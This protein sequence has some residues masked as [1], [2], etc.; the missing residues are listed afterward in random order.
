MDR[1]RQDVR[2]AL[3]ALGRTPL[4]AITVM[5]TL[6][7]GI[8]ASTAIFSFVDAIL[9]RALPYPDP[10][11]VVM[12]WE[13][14]GAGGGPVQEWFTPPDFEDLVEQSRTLSASTALVGWGPNLTGTAEPERLAGQ[15]VS[16][17]FFDVV[18]VQ[19]A[20]G[21]AFTAEEA[22]ADAR[23]VV[24]SHGLWQRSFGRD[25]DLVGRTI[26]LNGEDFTVIGIMPEGFRP[27]L[28]RV[29]AWR[30]Y[31]RGIFS[32]GC[33]RG[34]YVMQV[35]A[36]VSSDYD[37]EQA[38]AE[39]GAIG[40]SIVERF[41]A[42]KRDM[43]MT[44]V[45]L[46]AQ[47]AG[48]TFPALMALLAAVGLM[49]LIA[50]VNIANLLLARSGVREREIAVRAAIGA[51][52][53]VV[54]RQLLTESVVLGL[55][56][57]LVGII[58]AFW[59]VDL[60]IGMSPRGTPR[61]DEV[62]VN[63]PALL[64]AMGLAVTTGVLF[65]V[66]PSM[67]L[68]RL[69]VS[70]AIRESGGVRSSVARRRAR[71]ALVIAEIAITLA[72]LSG[73]GLLTRSFARLI[74]VDP[75]FRP[76][77][78][79]T[80]NVQLPAASYAD[81]AQANAFYG[82]LL[83]RLAAHPRVV[84]AGATSI[85]PLSGNNTDVSFAI[86][87]QTI[88]PG[89]V[90]GANYRT[91]TPGVFDALGMR[92]L[93]GRLL[94]EQDRE[95]TESV[96]VINQTMADRYWP[97]QDAIGGRISA[98]SR[99]GPWTTVVGIVA[100]VHHDGL[101]QPVRPGMYLPYHQVPDNGLILVVR[102]AGDPLDILPTVRS[103]IRAL[104][105]ELPLG[106][107]TTLDD[108]IAQSVGVPRLFVAFFGFF[109]VVA[110]LLAGVGIFGVTAHAVSQRTQE[111]GVRI[112]L[113]AKARD[114]IAIVVRQSMGITALGLVA[115]L[116]LALGLSWSLRAL[117]FRTSPTDPITFVAILVLFG[118]VALTA[119]VLPA[120]RAVRVDPVEALRRE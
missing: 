117:L 4:F 32:S 80:V 14:F 65:G 37:V 83:D 9:L 62:V 111:I 8:G 76:E 21:R 16:P 70:A 82:R 120:V 3:R 24:L 30:P 95:G 89:R 44:L 19:P 86:A 20:M 34:C 99:E 101:D 106:T 92:L 94:T 110:L 22:N 12:V 51:G 40:A 75:G 35:M 116:T 119:S 26:R 33:G 71:S 73:A 66:V 68:S 50:C 18:G 27:P 84:A 56:G 38:E 5:L 88:E 97:G 90:P 115:G 93:R 36:R 103:E 13:D 77:R 23:V 87:G 108:L 96:V 42:A 69:D 79:L 52:R 7:L 100:D 47:L 2:Y 29:D 17:A 102:T 39:V 49:L 48:P 6:G 67:Q 28:Q 61:L 63:G 10:G 85:L 107:T 105:P 114:V 57:G 64:V 81:A 74:A 15:V 55:A 113:G 1:L 98:E 104:D 59:G 109:G 78:T 46:Q 25:R 45:P 112:A 118:M 72:L 11:R 54:L 60:L 31:H 91:V 58:L 41:P 53:G 43:R